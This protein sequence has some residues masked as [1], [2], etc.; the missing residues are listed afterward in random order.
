MNIPPSEKSSDTSDTIYYSM[1]SREHQRFLELPFPRKYNYVRNDHSP[2]IIQV[3]DDY[4]ASPRLWCRYRLAWRMRRRHGYKPVV[5]STTCEN[6]HPFTGTGIEF[7]F[8]PS[9]TTERNCLSHYMLYDSYYKPIWEA[10][11]PDHERNEHREK[12]RNVT[13]TRFCCF[14]YSDDN[15]ETTVVRRNFCKLLTQYKRVDCPGESLNNMPRITWLRRPGYQR[16]KQDFMAS[17]KFSINFEHSSNDYYLTEKLPEALY[18]GAVPVYWGC[19][20]VAEYYNPAAFINCHDYPSFEDVVQRVIEVDNDP[21]LYEEYR[22]APPILPATRYYEMM[23]DL[24]KHCADIL[25][26][27]IARRARKSNV[28][29]DGLRLCWLVLRNL[30]LELQRICQPFYVPLRKKIPLLRRIRKFFR[31]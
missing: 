21:R 23:G 2:D 12:L 13:K 26:E 1:M 17:C 28:R 22:N 5:F 16:A 9:P 4:L 25:E 18:A 27:V 14:I 20:R 8:F 30:D 31:Q 29:Y 6:D 3:Y 11:L 24:E 19:P 7:S 15:I 10:L